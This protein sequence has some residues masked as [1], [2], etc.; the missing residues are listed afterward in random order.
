MYLPRLRH[1]QSNLL[2]QVPYVDVHQPFCKFGPVC[3]FIILPPQAPDHWHPIV[4]FHSAL[5]LTS[6]QSSPL[7]NAGGS[8]HATPS[9]GRLTV[10]AVSSH[11]L[12]APIINGLRAQARLV[13]TLPSSLSLLR[14]PSTMPSL[15]RH[16][17]S[18]HDVRIC[19]RYLSIESPRNLANVRA[20]SLSKDKR[21]KPRH[22]DR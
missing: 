21:A 3:Q 5:S 13:P 20:F 15:S 2:S 1:I 6:V 18:Q 17:I 14:P 22:T 19:G 10:A 7:R 16:T 12:R 4:R 11:V 8:E 9:H